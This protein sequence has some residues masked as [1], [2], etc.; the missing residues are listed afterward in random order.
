[1]KTKLMALL[2]MA[3]GSVF[4]QSGFSIGVHIGAPGYYRPA[5]APVVVAAYRTVRPG[6]GYIWI[7]PYQD[8]YGHRFNGYWALP[9]YAGAYWVAPRFSS[10]RFYS[11]YWAGSRGRGPNYRFRD[12][13]GHER[14]DNFNRGGTFGRGF[15]R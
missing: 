15:R 8:G 2:L 14:H 6:P 9:P 11:G 5:P 13:R 10:G 3:G 12:S 7:D 4:A 1:M